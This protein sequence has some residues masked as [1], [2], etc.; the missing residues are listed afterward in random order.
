MLIKTHIPLY[1]FYRLKESYS[2]YMNPYLQCVKRLDVSPKKQTNKEPTIQK[3]CF[4]P[5][6]L[7]L[8]ETLEQT[9]KIRQNKN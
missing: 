1:E 8:P 2:E 9:E 7:V 3:G 5:S 4:L 6:I